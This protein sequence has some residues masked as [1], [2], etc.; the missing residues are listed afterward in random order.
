MEQV[1]WNE[2]QSAHLHIKYTHSLVSIKLF[3]AEN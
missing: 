3:F 2:N 1:A